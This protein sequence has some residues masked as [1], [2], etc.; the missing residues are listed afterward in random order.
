M[1]PSRLLAFV[2]AMLAASPAIGQPKA[3]KVQPDKIAVGTVFTGATVEA[4]FMVFESGTDPKI[5]FEVTAPKFVKVLG[6]NTHYTQFGPGNDF[7][8]GT[9]EIAID[10]AAAAGHEGEVVVTLGNSKVKVPV[11][12]TVRARKKGFSKVLI[13]DTP[14]E[15]YT[16][17]D[18]GMFK[19]WTDLVAASP[20]DVSYI[21][22]RSGKPVVRD[23]DLSK[24]DC[25]FLDG[26]G[27][28]ALTED[29]LKKVRKYA[30]GGGRVV[31]SANYFFR[32][33]VKQAN[34]VLADFGIEMR[35]VEARG[36]GQNEVSIGK[37]DL[38]PRL[39]KDKIEMVTFFRASPVMVTD[40]KLGRIMVKA[41]G[42]G[43][44]GDGF[45]AL[46]TAG[47]GEVI[48]IGQSL[49][50][51]WI[52]PERS[53]GTDNAKLLRWLLVPKGGA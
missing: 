11:T 52:T 33:S 43:E 50:W 42:V 16:T 48:A 25:V 9:V 46:G 5:K 35:D 2:A 8:C 6:K 7:V 41:S 3:G 49:W 31:V 39:V 36:V 45:V 20:L 12:A 1:L 17:D 13:A 47:K 14:F 27:L 4:S 22:V 15:R 32:G 29:D 37:D 53:K 30:E 26:G 34:A 10:T 23:L 19:A 24:F 18:G 40:D 51:N 38:H 28:C 21:L 44:A